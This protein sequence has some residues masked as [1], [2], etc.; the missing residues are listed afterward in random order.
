[1]L[2][3]ANFFWDFGLNVRGHQAFWNAPPA[4]P[5]ALCANLT[6]VSRPGVTL[7]L[8]GVT[9]KRGSVLR[10][11]WLPCVVM[12]GSLRS[13]ERRRSINVAYQSKTNKFTHS[14]NQNQS[15]PLKTCD[16]GP[17]RCH[18]EQTRWCHRVCSQ[19]L[20]LHTVRLGRYSS[21]FFYRTQKYIFLLKMF[22]PS[23]FFV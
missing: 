22:F 9:S 2:I 18:I 5:N 4:F 23:N 8:P 11:I 16:T 3:L 15:N 14:T 20:G 7:S 19:K 12:K 10:L 6:F 17:A 21:V 13:Q 1:M